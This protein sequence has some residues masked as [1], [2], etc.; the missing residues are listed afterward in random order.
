MPPKRSLGKIPVF[1]KH[2][3]SSVYLTSLSDPILELTDWSF[4]AI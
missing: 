4:D 3:M 1:Q 2:K